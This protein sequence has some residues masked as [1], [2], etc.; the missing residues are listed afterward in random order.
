MLSSPQ[1][2][3]DPVKKTTTTRPL[4]GVGRQG[5]PQGIGWKWPNLLRRTSCE[6]L[7]C[8]RRLPLC[9]YQHPLSTGLQ[10][11]LR[12]KPHLSSSL[13]SL[14][15]F[16]T[17][18]GRYSTSLDCLE[19]LQLMKPRQR[20]GFQCPSTIADRWPG[21]Q[22]RWGKQ[23]WR[24]IERWPFSV[25]HCYGKAGEEK[26]R[27]GRTDSALSQAFQNQVLWCQKLKIKNSHL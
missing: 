5:Q 2:R 11:E 4:Q 22:G 17:L 23:R 13:R 27:M 19:C 12:P 25:S 18:P 21:W 24:G 16:R 1:R 8:K 10:L 20:F 26:S 3:P 6:D 7:S 14:Q 15:H 9:R